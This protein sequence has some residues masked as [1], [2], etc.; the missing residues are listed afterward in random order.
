MFVL[1][2][3]RNNLPVSVFPSLP[4]RSDRL[5]P[6]FRRPVYA[7]KGMTAA[8]LMLVLPVLSGLLSD[9]AQ[10]GLDTTLQQAGWSEFTFDEKRANQFTQPPGQPGLIQIDTDNSVSL[11]YL[12]FDGQPVRLDRTPYLSFSWRRLGPAVDTDLTRK[13]GDDRTL[14][15]YVAFPWQP[16]RASLKDRL[17]RPFVEASEGASAPGRVLTY[18]WG[19]GTD[20]GVWFENPYT[21]KAGWMQILQPP[22]AEGQT[23][24]THQI[25]IRADFED[26]FGYP[27]PDPSFIAVGA[28]SDDTAMRFSA[29]V[30]DLT[31]QADKS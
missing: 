5:R 19:G 29:Q 26:R 6:V 16:E 14:A 7:I 8:G 27:P 25:N 28:D 20:T 30:R 9:P 18:M 3:L 17:L 1:T 22:T 21:G 23:W 2:I 12:R 24:F 4:R 10:A 13:G 15:I 31:F 11:A